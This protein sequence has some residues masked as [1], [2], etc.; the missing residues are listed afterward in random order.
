MALT[1]CPKCG[2]TVSDNNPFCPH[3]GAGIAKP[4]TPTQADDATQSASSVAAEQQTVA[5]GQQTAAPD[6]APTLSSQQPPVQAGQ[7]S[8]PYP[9]PA[10]QKKSNPLLWVV[11]TLI[12]I[13]IALAVLYFTVFNKK[14]AGAIPNDI[15]A[16]EQQDNNVAAEP[17][18][19]TQEELAA[20]AAQQ[21]ALRQDSI[22]NAETFD[23]AMSALLNMG[24]LDNDGLEKLLKRLGFKGS[25]KNGTKKVDEGEGFLREYTVVKLNYTLTAGDKT[26]KFVRDFEDSL[27]WCGC[28]DE[29]TIKGDDKALNNFFNYAKRNLGMEVKKKGN[30][31]I[32]E[33]GWT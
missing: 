4:T 18:G 20:Q 29:V 27:S 7:P 31:V 6:N 17:A 1:K 3:C 11:I 32:I 23:K 12:A 10:P 16:V 30:T 21:E 25:R 2:N 26:I 19:P 28:T 14:E 24:D 13:A 9:A 8:M 33:E 5:V 15:P 22:R